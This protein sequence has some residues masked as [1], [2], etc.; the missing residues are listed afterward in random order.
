MFHGRKL[1]SRINRIH[2]KAL[3]IVYQDNISSFQ[4]LLQKDESKTIHQRN[5]QVLVTEIF[6]I[7]IG[8]VPSVLTELLV[9]RSSY[10]SLRN[11]SEF[12]RA[13]KNTVKY[14]ENSLTYLAPIIWD[15]LPSEIK[16]VEILFNPK[17][18]LRTLFLKTAVAGYVRLTFKELDFYNSYN[19]GYLR[20]TRFSASSF[21]TE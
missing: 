12:K 16:L 11:P 15:R 20:I 3:Q 21:V 19:R 10:Y 17:K 14:G 9:Y 7:K 5:L 8:T 13:H 18:L 1:N 2:G 4:Q 6:K